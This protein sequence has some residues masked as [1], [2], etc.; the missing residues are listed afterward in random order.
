[1]DTIHEIYKHF[2]LWLFSKIIRKKLLLP[3]IVN[4][5]KKN[6]T[7]VPEEQ[8]NYISNMIKNYILVI[9]LKDYEREVHEL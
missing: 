6:N 2:Y 1:M 4:C 5:K 8:C 7:T 3:F 9:I